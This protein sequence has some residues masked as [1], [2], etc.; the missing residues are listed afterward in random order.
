MLNHHCDL[1]MALWLMM[2]YHQVWLQ[3]A[4]RHSRNNNILIV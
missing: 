1:D 3:S 4:E 2:M